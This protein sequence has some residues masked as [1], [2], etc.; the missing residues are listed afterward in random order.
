MRPP[1]VPSQILTKV[2]HW[3]NDMVMAFDQNGEQIPALQGKHIEV[4]LDIAKA[5][6]PA[7]DFCRGIFQTD[8]W[9]VKPGEWLVGFE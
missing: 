5:S 2:I 1:L 4:W 6:T 8:V 9:E 7:T 3:Q